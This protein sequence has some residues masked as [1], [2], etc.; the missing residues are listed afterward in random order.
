VVFLNRFTRYMTTCRRQPI[1]LQSQVRTRDKSDGLLS[2]GL[3][4][5]CP[6][7]Y[8]FFYITL[9]CSVFTLCVSRYFRQTLSA[10]RYEA[11]RSAPAFLFSFLHFIVPVMKPVPRPSSVSASFRFKRGICFGILLSAI[12]C[13][14][15]IQI[16]FRADSI[17]AYFQTSSS[18]MWCGLVQPLAVLKYLN[19]SGYILLVSL[20]LNVP[21]LFPYSTA[22]R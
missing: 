12:F 6:L 19:S 20:A 9:V 1:P 11:N 5:S 22:D 13:R 8:S 14:L 18:S 17:F 21:G 15:L 7:H 16:E 3:Y 4:T 10:H 2:S